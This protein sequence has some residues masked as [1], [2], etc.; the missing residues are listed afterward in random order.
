MVVFPFPQVR[1]WHQQVIRTRRVVVEKVLA[2]LRKHGPTH[3][4]G[5]HLRHD[6]IRDGRKNQKAGKN[7]F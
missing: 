5:F 6:E 3:G 4:F 2:G 1:M 7:A